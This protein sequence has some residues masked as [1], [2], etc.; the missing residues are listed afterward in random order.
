MQKAGTKMAKRKIKATTVSKKDANKKQ[1]SGFLKSI[2]F[3]FSTLFSNPNCV[4]GR[5][6][7]WYTAL[8]VAIASCFV[9]T[10]ATMVNYFSRSG[11]AFFDLPNYSL[12]TSLTDFEKALDD[13]G[14]SMKIENGKMSVNAEEWKKVCKDNEGNQKNFYGHYYTVNKVTLKQESGAASDALPTVPTSETITYCDLAVYFVDNTTLAGK[15]TY[16]YAAEV[17][18]KGED[19][20]FSIL[21][22]TTSKDF[23]TN[24]IV[25]GENEFSA[26]KKPAGTETVNS[27]INGKYDF[28]VNFD[29]KDLYKQNMKGHAYDSNAM[30]AARRADVLASYK[31]FFA[32]AY[33]STKT[34]MAWQYTGIAYAINFGLVFL[35][36]LMIYLMT[37]GKNNPFREYKFIDGLKISAWASITPALLALLGF[38]PFFASFSMFIFLFLMGMRIMWMSTRTLRPYLPQQQ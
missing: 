11:A 9:A 17:I 19:P 18:L 35:F 4:E 16:Q 21:A 14:V 22:N 7:P 20:N 36:G 8:I 29:L 23:A 30:T 38:L 15:T 3:F 25:F 26:F 10:L 27:A 2:G 37:R 31:L 28:G 32:A 24:L 33:E 13:N 34:I 12:D 1:K 6:K 5:K